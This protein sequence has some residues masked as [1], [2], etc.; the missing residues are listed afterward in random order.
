MVYEVGDII[1][2]FSLKVNGHGY[3]L[4]KGS[5]E[6]VQGEYLFVRDP[7]TKNLTCVHDSQVL[8]PTELLD[9]T[10]YFI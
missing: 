3:M 5:I 4:R 6:K 7:R 8:N 1:T 9:D 10:D 2:V